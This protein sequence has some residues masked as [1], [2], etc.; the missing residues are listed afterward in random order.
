MSFDTYD[1]IM[2]YICK[3]YG[4]QIV[5]PEDFDSFYD[6]LKTI[7]LK[8]PRVGVVRDRIEVF[9]YLIS[10]GR[11]SVD[12]L[13]DRVYA[14]FMQDRGKLTVDECKLM[15]LTY[16]STD[17]IVQGLENKNENTALAVQTSL[18][19]SEVAPILVE[20]GKLDPLAL[21]DEEYKV[22]KG[23]IDL[24]K[25]KILELQQTMYL[26][27]HSACYA[28][29]NQLT[30]EYGY[31][32]L[33]TNG[34]HNRLCEEIANLVGMQENLKEENRILLLTIMDKKKEVDKRNSHVTEKIGEER[35][36]LTNILA[37]DKANLLLADKFG[38]FG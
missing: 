22:N 19:T 12:E 38:D 37:R 5:H 24:L 9:R 33:L 1:L 32:P 29:I 36:P 27:E 35:K 21:Y 16:I 2:Q 23:R 34:K 11:A 26:M 20:Q 17:P 4:R 28:N 14:N 7:Q 31:D 3:I 10:C 13:F 25:K 30:G 18:V 6:T 8:L 15:G